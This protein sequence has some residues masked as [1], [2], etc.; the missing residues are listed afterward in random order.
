MREGTEMHFAAAGWIGWVGVN[1]S[2]KI[3]GGDLTDFIPDRV[4]DKMFVGQMSFN[5][6]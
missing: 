5:S 4:H 3:G 2:P 6:Y 1:A